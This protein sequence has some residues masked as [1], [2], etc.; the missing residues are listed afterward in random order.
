MKHLRFSSQ[1]SVLALLSLLAIPASTTAAEPANSS[2]PGPIPYASLDD[3][4]KALRAKPGVTFRQE[5]G[6]LV[7][8]DLDTFTVWLL[9]P[10]E[11][12]AYPS[13]VRRTLINQ[14]DGAY[15]DTSVRCLASKEVCDRAFGGK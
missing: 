5:G 11:H 9:T 4:L 10:A 6:W 15:M 12:P 7:A 13:M 2:R 1:I 14:S 3:A 8:E